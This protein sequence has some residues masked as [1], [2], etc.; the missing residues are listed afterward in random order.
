MSSVMMRRILGSRQIAP[1]RAS[2]TGTPVTLFARM[3]CANMVAPVREKAAEGL[4]V[5]ASLPAPGKL[6]PEDSDTQSGVPPTWRPQSWQRPRNRLQAGHRFQLPTHTAL[7]PGRDLPILVQYP[8]Q[9]GGQPPCVGR[10]RPA[11]VAR[12]F[13]ISSRPNSLSTCSYLSSKTCD[14]RSSRSACAG[15]RHP[16]SLSEMPSDWRNSPTRSF[17]ST[18]FI[19][20]APAQPPVSEHT[21]DRI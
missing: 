14:S 18:K 12:R 2:Y 7:E 17:A 21:F 16:K 11:L 8:A 19:A 4:A 9:Y 13:A 1:I 15:K 5:Q 10:N 3:I 6:L 20:L